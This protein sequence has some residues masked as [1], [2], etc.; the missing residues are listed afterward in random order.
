MIQSTFLK[1]LLIN[2]SKDF[3]SNVN[4]INKLFFTLFNIFQNIKFINTINLLAAN[5][6]KQQIISINGT[7]ISINLIFYSFTILTNLQYDKS[8]FKRLLIN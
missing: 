3:L 6:I 7:I 4:I 2:I 1:K 5:I 8:K